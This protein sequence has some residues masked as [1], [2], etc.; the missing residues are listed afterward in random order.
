MFTKN[1]RFHIT[2]FDGGSGGSCGSSGSG[3]SCWS[4]GFS[5]SFEFDW[6]GRSGGPRGSC[7]PC[8]DVGPGGSCGLMGL[9]GLLGLVGL[10]GLVGIV[11]LTGRQNWGRGNGGLHLNSFQP[12]SRE[13]K[14]CKVSENRNRGTKRKG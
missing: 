5:G 3:G 4:S 1:I 8:L 7:G 12:S 10:V 9:V 13:M 14:Q 2:S 6:L 11:S